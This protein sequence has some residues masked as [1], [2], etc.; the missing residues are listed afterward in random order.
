ML[1]GHPFEMC[2]LGVAMLLVKNSSMLQNIR[3]LILCLEL[4][5]QIKKVHIRLQEF[6]FV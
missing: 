2:I 6:A 5:R 1:E 4:P 3:E